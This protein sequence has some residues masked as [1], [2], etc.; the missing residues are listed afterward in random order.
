MKLNKISEVWNNTNR[1]LSDF[2]G[3][4]SFKNWSDDTSSLLSQLNSP[5]SLIAVGRESGNIRESVKIGWPLKKALASILS[6]IW[7]KL[8]IKIKT[9]LL[10][11]GSY[12]IREFRFF[13]SVW[14]PEDLLI[15]LFTP[16]NSKIKILAP[17]KFCSVFFTWMV[18]FLIR[19]IQN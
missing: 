9:Q 14:D 2:I 8:R 19:K 7:I 3:L 17:G 10:S 13:F 15:L 5:R 1:L 6:L 4:L 18:T 12:Q 16:Q 11:N